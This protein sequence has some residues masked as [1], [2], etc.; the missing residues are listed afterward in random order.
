MRYTIAFASRCGAGGTSLASGMD[1]QACAEILSE[2]SGSSNHLATIKDR[3][4]ES[5]K[6]LFGLWRSVGVAVLALMAHVALAQASTPQ[7]A[8]SPAAAR[9]TI[10]NPHHLEVPEDRVRVLLLTTCRVV[11]EEFHR[12]S[13]EVDLRVT[14]VL[15]DPDERSMVDQQ[16]NLT[17]YMDHWNQGKFVDGVITGAVQNLTT[18]KARNKMFADILRRSDEIAPVS[19]NRLR[20]NASNRPSPGLTL[21][22]DCISALS[23]APCSWSNQMP[24]LR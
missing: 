24:P 6:R 2:S 21:P 22:P 7:G 10:V 4:A 12:H 14:L 9:L 16:G 15:G 20:G 13:D 17:L 1:A 8:S 19:V 11:A 23:D 3:V 18:L 5:R